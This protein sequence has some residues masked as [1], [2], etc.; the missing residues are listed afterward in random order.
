LLAGLNLKFIALVILAFVALNDGA[1]APTMKPTTMKP[2]T[3]KPS[4]G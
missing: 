2:T 3:I 4:T 1:A